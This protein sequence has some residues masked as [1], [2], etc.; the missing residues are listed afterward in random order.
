MEGNEQRQNKPSI[1]TS[2]KKKGGELPG[3]TSSTRALIL[4]SRQEPEVNVPTK[5]QDF[6]IVHFSTK[7]GS[8]SI[9]FFAA[10]AQEHGASFELLHAPRAP[11]TVMLRYSEEA[12]GCHSPIS[13]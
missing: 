8:F 6:S 9:L 4:T 13:A 2:R 12:L 5:E 10:C 1:L 11:E 3:S 7:Y